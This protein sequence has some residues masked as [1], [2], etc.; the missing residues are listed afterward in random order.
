MAA[1]GFAL[2]GATLG[3]A[4]ETYKK[5]AAPG[6]ALRGA[7][8]GSARLSNDEKPLRLMSCVVFLLN[9]A[10]LRLICRACGGIAAPGFAQRRASPFDIFI[11]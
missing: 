6:F 4:Y 10:P 8:L 5:M 11:S 7:L 3:S 1:P 2:R 9:G